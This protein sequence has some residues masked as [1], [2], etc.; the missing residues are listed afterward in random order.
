MR[1]RAAPKSTTAAE[2][3]AT[4]ASRRQIGATTV[5]FALALLLFFTFLLGIMDFA[6]MLF[7]WSAA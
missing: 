7:I 5:E 1:R 6:R 3:E 4:P 2:G